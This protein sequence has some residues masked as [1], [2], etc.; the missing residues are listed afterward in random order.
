MVM[1]DCTI[2][3]AGVPNGVGITSSSLFL[4]HQDFDESTSTSALSL[5]SGC[6]ALIVP[7]FHLEYILCELNQLLCELRR[8]RGQGVQ[9]A[10][11][12]DC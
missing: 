4:G 11:P 2:R 7:V 5:V 8:D 9:P 10:R 12:L 1:E 3:V 6:A